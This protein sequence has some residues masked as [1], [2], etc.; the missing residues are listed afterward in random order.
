VIPSYFYIEEMAS[1]R[2]YC[3][4]DIFDYRELKVVIVPQETF[5]QP[6][7]NDVLAGLV[8]PLA[9]G[10]YF[11]VVDLFIIPDKIRAPLISKLISF[12]QSDIT[13]STGEFFT[14]HYPEMLKMTIEHIIENK[15]K[16]H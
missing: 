2:V 12:Y 6:V 5:K 8:L 1:K 3:L 11:S 4:Y 7:S 9:D 16:I 13:I 14:R 10:G 15:V